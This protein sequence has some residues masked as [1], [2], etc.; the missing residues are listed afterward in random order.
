MP[1]LLAEADRD[2]YRREKAMVA[3]EKE[4]MKD[5]PDWEVSRV[6]VSDLESRTDC[7]CGASG[8]QERVQHEALHAELVRRPL[9]WHADTAVRCS[10][11]RPFR[12]H[13]VR[14]S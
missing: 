5:V 10:N 8:G 4:I 7:V 14:V 13:G 2:V 11:G 1:L 12:S 3:R 9:S 6:S